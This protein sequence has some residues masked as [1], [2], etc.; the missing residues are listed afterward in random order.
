MPITTSASRPVR[1]S[2]VP[3]QDR[4]AALDGVQGLQD[5]VARLREAVASHPLDLADPDRDAGQLGG[6]WVDLDALDVGRTDLRERPLETERLR[7]ELHP[8][9]QVLERL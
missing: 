7:L 1:F 3:R 4:V 5:R 6:I 9:L 8:V 2:A